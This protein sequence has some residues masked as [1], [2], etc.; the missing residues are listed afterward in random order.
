[1]SGASCEVDATAAELDEEEDIE[2]GQPDGVDGEEV[3]GQDLVGVLADELA[4]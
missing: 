3:G 1:V 2:P 4:P